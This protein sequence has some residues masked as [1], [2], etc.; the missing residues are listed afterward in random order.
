MSGRESQVCYNSLMESVTLKQRILASD[1]LPTVGM[2]LITAGLIGLI[3]SSL[4]LTWA[5]MREPWTLLLTAVVV[6]VSL[7][8]GLVGAVPALWILLGPELLEQGRLNGGPFAV[9]DRVMIITGPHRGTVST[10][11]GHWQSGTNRVQLGKEARENHADIFGDY[12]LLR[13][14]AP[15]E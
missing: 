2:W 7:L 11:Y 8:L 13:C 3:L 12:Q 1:R 4:D 14:D 5:A 10:V 15:E 9:G 6:G